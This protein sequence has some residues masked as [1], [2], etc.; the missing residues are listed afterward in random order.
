MPFYFKTKKFTSFLKQLNLYGFEKLKR[1]TRNLEFFHS[2]FNKLNEERARDIVHKKSN[3]EKGMSDSDGDSFGSVGDGNI[4]RGRGLK[5]KI[6]KMNLDY[7]ALTNTHSDLKA[8]IDLTNT[9]NDVLHNNKSELLNDLFDINRYQRQCNK[10][11][12]EMLFYLI[13]NYNDHVIGDIKSLLTD[14]NVYNPEDPSFVDDPLPFRKQIPSIMSFL[15]GD[16]SL[17]K[18]FYNKIL[19]IVESSL[20]D[21]NSSSDN[22]NKSRKKEESPEIGASANSVSPEGVKD[23]ENNSHDVYDNKGKTEAKF[24]N[25]AKSLYGEDGSEEN[26]SSESTG[27]IKRMYKKRDFDSLYRK[28]KNI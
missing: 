19:K 25:T 1:G 23:R 11:S 12:V 6:V 2:D 14:M 10:K 5:G 26:I 9:L 22:L 20:D 4:A 13:A 3:S 16:G 24:R 18:S 21:N 27:S 7:Q 28:R 17:K 8:R 15:M